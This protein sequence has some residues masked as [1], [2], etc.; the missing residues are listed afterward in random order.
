VSC[1]VTYTPVAGFR[2]DKKVAGAQPRTATITFAIAPDTNRS[3]LWAASAPGPFGSFALTA[4][5]QR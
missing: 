4:N 2:T 1:R 3:M 5:S